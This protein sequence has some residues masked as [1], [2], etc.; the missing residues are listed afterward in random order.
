MAQERK[1]L[2][3]R[4]IW[5]GAAIVVVLVFF[6][7]RSLTR[8]RLQVRVMR[9]SRQELV[10]VLSTNGRVE[11][12]EN[13]EIHAPVATTVRAVY[14]RPGD[15]VEAGKVLAVLDDVD[16]RARVAAAESGVRSAQALLEAATHNGTQEQQQTSAADIARARLEH[17]QAERDLNALLKLQ[18]TG[19]ASASEVSGAKQRLMSA[20]ATLDAAE[21]G[22]RSRYSPAEVERARA[23]LA[24]AQANLAA[25]RDTEENDGARAGD[26][27]A[28]QHGCAADIVCG[29]RQA[30]DA[31]CQSAADAGTGF[32]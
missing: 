22:S 16:T 30:D 11:P 6:G 7:V 24:D 21:S 28:L 19:A 13:H 17:D 32:L 26:G 25:A 5:A 1:Q 31:D 29:S 8:E 3:W 23:A 10:S 2:D 27:N 18:A 9:V 20:T 14:V 15:T 4:W 12:E